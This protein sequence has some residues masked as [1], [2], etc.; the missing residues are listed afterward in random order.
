MIRDAGYSYQ[1]VV[2]DSGNLYEETKSFDFV[3]LAAPPC[4]VASSSRE[5]W[6]EA[7]RGAARVGSLPRRSFASVAHERRAIRDVVLRVTRNCKCGDDAAL[8]I[9]FTVDCVTWITLTKAR[10]CVGRRHCL[11]RQR[12][13]V[14]SPRVRQV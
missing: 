2:Y 11:R 9:G 14:C 5:R 1:V 12:A 6:N 7:P 4:S 10:V 13:L 3:R 8:C